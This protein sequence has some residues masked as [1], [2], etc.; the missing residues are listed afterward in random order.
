MK[1]I[2]IYIRRATAK[3]KRP[4]LMS[5]I[6]AIMLTAV[7]S[8][9]PIYIRYLLKDIEIK[10]SYIALFCGIGIY[11]L[12]LLV[13]NLIDIFWYRSIDVFA[14]EFIKDEM[15]ILE[16]KIYFL[17]GNQLDEFSR[18]RLSH[19]L[20]QNLFDMF[21]VIGHHLAS[22]LT[23]TLLVT[24]SMI[25][26]YF[27]DFKLF[28]ILS[29]SIAATLVIS[30]YSRKIIQNSSIEINNKMRNIH[31][32]AA[33][34]TAKPEQVWR[35]SLLNYYYERTDDAVD[36]FITAAK[37]TDLK[38]V[39]FSNLLS[40]INSLF[41]LAIS[42]YFAIQYKGNLASLV[43]II[44][45]ANLISQHSNKADILLQQVLRSY[46][47]FNN[48]YELE[49]LDER[50]TLSSQNEFKNE[51]D[52]EMENTINKIGRIEKIEFR[53]L[54]FKYPAGTENIYTDFNFT[55]QAGDCIKLQA[56]NGRGKS[57]LFRII[58]NI[59]YTN[60]DMY[61]I[62]GIDVRTLPAEFFKKQITYIGQDNSF[63]N[64][65]IWK[66]LLIATGSESRSEM[67]LRLKQKGL[68]K[69][70][71]LDLE[72]NDLGASLSFGQRKKI[73]LLLLALTYENYSVFLFDE[74]EA[75]LDKEGQKI[76]IEIIEKMQ[77]D[78]KIIFFVNHEDSLLQHNKLIKL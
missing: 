39:F 29:A 33:E 14:G 73:D 70:I 64:D 66:Y 52:L 1:I 47:A 36:D 31:T 35:R 63:I 19:V 12:L 58:E 8:F 30:F 16:R 69:L 34:Y 26:V 41:I 3:F 75:G 50:M 67:E 6:W 20:Y 65:K 76:F 51:P 21:R 42:A 48:I 44:T 7:Y 15:K 78:K 2:L 4:F 46:S 74:V 11:M 60:T 53:N 49:N 56:S 37:K 28:A 17:Y 57:T 72:I 40:H 77:E 55:C 27:Y 22:I 10:S 18:P 45:L 71:D 62:N 23:S 43:Y 24:V 68:D 54:S 13:N 38:Q 5:L 61:F 9:T 25:L 32:L 59:Y